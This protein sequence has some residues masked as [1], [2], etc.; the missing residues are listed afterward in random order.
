MLDL[1]GRAQQPQ[2]N[3]PNFR[4]IL[5]WHQRQTTWYRA[6]T[7]K[8]K[9]T[10]GASASINSAAGPRDMMSSSVP[11]WQWRTIMS[12][13]AMPLEIWQL[14]LA[15]VLSSLLQQPWAPSNVSL[16]QK[17]SPHK[18][19]TPSP[20]AVAMCAPILPAS[21]IPA[22]TFPHGNLIYSPSVLTHPSSADSIN[23]S[24]QALCDK[25]KTSGWGL[26]PLWAQ[27]QE[28]H[29]PSLSLMVSTGTGEIFGQQRLSLWTPTIPPG[30]AELIWPS[31]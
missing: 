25:G 26:D 22:F 1:C 5:Y 30:A 9:G 4:K 18:L 24:V 2:K 6:E 8:P 15:P 11:E 28:F 3:P 13:L 7:D 27:L 29:V 16:L 23:S 17:M 20:T 31:P 19:Q 10:A 12:G 14:K 21:S